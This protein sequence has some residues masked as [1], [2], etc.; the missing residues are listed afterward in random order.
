LDEANGSFDYGSDQAL[1][2]GLLALKGE[3]TIVIIT[4][5]PS[6][7]A[8]ADRRFTLIDGKFC[9]LEQSRSPLKAADQAT[10]AVA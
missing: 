4:N 10:E 8:I 7:A 9:P 3:V 5:R 1:G 2:K 6:F